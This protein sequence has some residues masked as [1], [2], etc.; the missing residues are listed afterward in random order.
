ME[1]RNSFRIL[2]LFSKLGSLLTIAA[3]LAAAAFAQTEY[4]I[5]SGRAVDKQ[6]AVLAGAIVKLQPG[7]YRIATNEQGEFT[8]TGLTPG[9]YTLTISYLGFLTFTQQV[10]VTAGQASH[11][12]A[13]LDVSGK[14]EEI[15]V[16]GDR[17][18]GEAEAI[19][20]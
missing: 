3:L 17:P 2:F 7:E 18:H 6:G 9:S 4:G 15:T 12:E 13:R 8:I 11:I 14:S 10:K 20:R 19:N 1:L 16:I 5:I